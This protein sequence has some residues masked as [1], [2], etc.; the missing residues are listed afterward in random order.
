MRI[1]C[2]DCHSISIRQWNI[3]NLECEL[4]SSND[5]GVQDE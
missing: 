1:I 2:N 5:V 4:C 3:D